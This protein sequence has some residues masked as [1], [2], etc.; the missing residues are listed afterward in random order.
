[1]SARTTT[2]L[3]PD[4][5]PELKSPAGK[6]YIEGIKYTTENVLPSSGAVKQDFED[7]RKDYEDKFVKNLL[8]LV[9]KECIARYPGLFTDNSS[10]SIPLW[11]DVNH[12]STTND[13]KTLTWMFCTVMLAGIILPLPAETNEKIELKAGVWNGQEGIRGA[14]IQKSFQRETEVWVSLLPTAL[15]TIPG[16]SDFPKISGT[17]LDLENQI[18]AYELATAQQITTALAKS[19]AGK[20]SN[21]WAAVPSS[22]KSAVQQS[23]PEAIPSSPNTADPF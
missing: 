10:S 9:R 7:Q 18:A 3:K 23:L 21:Y 5:N 12:I 8:P 16:E 4:A 11:V 22:Q 6:F 14:A 19:V 13:T 15:I 20:G 1:M 2:N 17:I